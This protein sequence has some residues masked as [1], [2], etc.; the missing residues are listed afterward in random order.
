M[1]FDDTAFEA[2]LKML[3]AVEHYEYS[4]EHKTRTIQAI[5]YLILIDIE[6]NT[7]GVKEARKEATKRWEEAYA[8]NKSI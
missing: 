6:S 1:G 5:T 3:E 8:K 4:K 2:I 7:F